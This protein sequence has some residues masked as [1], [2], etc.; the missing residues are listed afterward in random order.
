MDTSLAD[1]VIKYWLLNTAVEFGVPLTHIFPEVSQALNV[2][3]V[4]GCGSEDY[5][6][7]LV[8]LFDS[9]MIALSSEV[10]GDDTRSRTGVLQ[11]LDRFRMLSKD[12]VTLRTDGRLLKSYQLRRLSRMQVSFR[13][14]PL[15]GEAWE[16]I[17]QPDWA[18]YVSVST[19]SASGDVISADRDLLLAYMGWYPEVNREQIQLQT[20]R[21]QT[22][23][24][25]E[26]VYWKR[27]PFVYHA[28]FEV[29]PAEARWVS[30]EPKWFR[31]WW[32]STCTWYK[33]PWSLSGWPSE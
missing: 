7:G 27:L 31:D 21:W 29:Q 2:K 1:E 10:E 17:A 30:G 23:T 20:M 24:D 4:P 3:P 13:L 18:R 6:S 12:D 33:Q 11:I 14:T 19:V 22:H 28:S 5:A 26:I 32:V 25:F 9:G 16:K 15:G 8:E